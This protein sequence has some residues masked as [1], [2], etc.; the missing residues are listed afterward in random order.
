MTYQS[1]TERL[2]R[3]APLLGIWHLSASPAFVESAAETGVDFV[4]MDVQ[5]GTFDFEK[6]AE[7][8]AR[9]TS[10]GVLSAVRIAANDYA[11]AGRAVDAGVDIV[12]AP[13]IDTPVDARALV[14]AVKY[15]PVGGRSWGPGGAMRYQG[16]TDGNRYLQVANERVTALAMI[17]TALAFEN[18]DAIL[19]VDGLDGVLVGPSDLSIALSNG[20]ELDP[21][22][23]RSIDAIAEI[24]KAADQSNKIAAI[25][26][27]REAHTKTAIDL[28]YQVITVATDL[29]LF[30]GAVERSLKKWR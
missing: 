14:D 6:L 26:T 9:S 11:F 29:G 4:V 21:F 25:F 22:G 23:A 30:G 12:I 19:A 7:S 27:N 17:E 20:A 15:P 2:S 18:L 5:H 24:A 1:L 16:E 10:A 28:G 8:L 13:L 3:S